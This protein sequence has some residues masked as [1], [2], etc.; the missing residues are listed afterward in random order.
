MADRKMKR[1]KPQLLKGMQDSWPEVARARRR[2]QAVITEVCEGFGFL[3]LDTPTLEA[4]EALVGPEPTAEQLDSIFHFTNNDEVEVGLRYE[5]TG[6]LARV[7]SQYQLEIA[8][9]FRRYQV[10]NVFRWDKPAPGR[11]REFLQFDVDTVGAASMAADAEIIAVIVAILDRLGVS[12]YRVR[13]SNRKLLNALG[14]FAGAAP[15]Q[16]RDIYRVID[17]LDKFDRDRIRRE[18]GPG[19]TDESG[20]PIPGLGLS[21][22]QVA[23]I[24]LFLDLPTAGDNAATLVAARGLL[25]GIALATAG[26]DEIEQVLEFVD[27]FGVDPTAVKFDLHLARGLGYYSGPVFEVVLTDLPG[28]GSIFGGGRYDGLVERFLGAGQGIPAVGASVGVDRLLAAL[29]ELGKLSEPYASTQVLV[30]VMDKSRLADYIRLTRELRDAGIIAETF[31]GG[32]N[33]GKQLK[34]ADRLGIPLAVI[35]GEDEFAANELSVKDLDLGRRIAAEAESREEWRE[36]KQ[37][38]TVGRD[39]LVARLREALNR[40]PN[41]SR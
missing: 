23:R 29:R 16:G 2:M 17:K 27:A 10:G 35:A 6:S 32:G 20:D 31:L 5:L 34:Y 30:T 41:Q 22:E 33:L 1:V 28:F 14:E 37:Q 8:R 7:V 15:D 19:L 26:L 40:G 39:E 12:G 3:P 25:G 21:A 18:L 13:L 24:D 38:F 9:P 4:R 36:L 11:F